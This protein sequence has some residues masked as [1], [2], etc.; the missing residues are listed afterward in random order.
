M[1]RQNS[2]RSRSP[3]KTTRG[4]RS[5]RDDLLRAAA[6]GAKTTTFPA[7]LGVP[8]LLAP[9]G[10]LSILESIGLAPSSASGSGGSSAIDGN[11]DANGNGK[12]ETY[13]EVSPHEATVTASVLNVRSGPSMSSK[14]IDTVTKGA[15][16]RVMGAIEGGA[17][18]FVD[19]GG[20]TG[21][22]ATKYLA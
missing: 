6:G 15:V 11:V 9:I 8:A 13:V 12:N 19:H 17:W 14:I 5:R 2:S 22:L 20:K 18:S 10:E 16:V 3:G 21:F 1:T 4:C 7:A